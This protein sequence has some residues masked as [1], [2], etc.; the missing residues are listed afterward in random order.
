MARAL[1]MIAGG[2]GVTPMLQIVRGIA[3]N[4]EDKTQ[5]SLIYANVNEE[6][7]LLREEIDAIVASRPGQ[8][9]AYFV[10]NNPPAGWTGGVGFV[11][12]DHISEHLPAPAP[13]VKILMCGP[14]P[15]LNAMKFVVLGV[16]CCPCLTLLT[17]RKNLVDLKYDEARTVSK[18]DDQVRRLRS[19]ALISLI[20]TF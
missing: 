6:D 11:S 8:I 4:P 5:V 15:M 1:G 3:R 7:I 16:I 17:C 12:K 20:A 14:P 10:L 19:Y 2:S 9:R 18:V 13:D